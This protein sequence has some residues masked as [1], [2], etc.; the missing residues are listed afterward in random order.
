MEHHSGLYLENTLTDIFLEN[1]Q[2]DMISDLYTEWSLK[3]S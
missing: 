3:I 1:T 2:E